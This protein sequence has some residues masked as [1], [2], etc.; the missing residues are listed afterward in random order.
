MKKEPVVAEA[1]KKRNRGVRRKVLDSGGDADHH[2][3]RIAVVK[4]GGSSSI[5]SNTK[6]KTPGRQRGSAAKELVGAATLYWLCISAPAIIGCIVRVY[7]EHILGVIDAFQSYWVSTGD[8]VAEQAAEEATYYETM[9]SYASYYSNK[10]ASYACG[11]MVTAEWCEVVDDAGEEE[12]GLFA[13]VRKLLYRDSTPVNDLLLVMTSA[14]CLAMIRVL[15]VSLLVPRALAPQRLA[16]MT[17]CKSTHILSSSS[18]YEFSPAVKRKTNVQGSL[19]GN[20]SALAAPDLGGNQGDEAD[21]YS[22][23]IDLEDSAE[24][25]DARVVLFSERVGRIWGTTQESIRRSLGHE[26]VPADE[27]KNLDATAA[28]QRIFSAPRFATAFFRCLYCSASCL[29]AYSLFRT[30]NF[31]PVYVGG[32]ASSSTRNCWD[33][34]GSIALGSLDSDFDHNNAALRIFFLAQGAYQLHSLWFHVLSM[35]LLMLYEEGNERMISMKTSMKS[36]LRPLA[37]HLISL[38][39]IFL[40]YIFSGLRRLGA[41]GIFT[42]ESSS[43]SLQLLQ[44]CINAPES[45]PLR[46]PKLIKRLHRYLVVPSFLYCRFFVFPFIVWYSAAFESQD[47]LE[48]IEKAFV[49]GSAFVL[50]VIF[51]LMISFIFGLNLVFFRRLLFHPHLQDIFRQAREE[52]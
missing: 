7:E 20:L 1:G 24:D 11:Y 47:W 19:R 30:A 10:A 37:E 3:P 52:Q 21:D 28:A 12:T 16:A 23:Q 49:P 38:T 27:Y 9:S 25:D 5:S 35:A 34:S 45:S 14:M 2:N 51:N 26:P 22:N 44:V 4:K 48:Q 13:T 31:W 18:S 17:R 50:Y 42:L 36:Y 32:L 43:I 29:M 8:A 15:L 41:V 40:C 6:T 33:R 46:R 39:L